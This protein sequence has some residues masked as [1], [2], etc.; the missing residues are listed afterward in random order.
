MNHA[1]LPSPFSLGIERV[2]ILETTPVAHVDVM[3]RSPVHALVLE[4]IFGVRPFQF[5][6][7]GETLHAFPRLPAVRTRAWMEDQGLAF[8]VTSGGMASD[9]PVTWVQGGF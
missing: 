5:S 8:V 7:R 3:T 1:P 6:R 2:A 9:G 4:S